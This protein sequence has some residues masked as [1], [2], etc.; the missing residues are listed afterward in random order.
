MKKFITEE[1]REA[2]EAIISTIKK[3]AEKWPT[4]FV[5]RQ[6]VPIFTGGAVSARTMANKDNL[7]EGPSCSFKIFKSV[8]YPVDALCDWLIAES[9]GTKRRVAQ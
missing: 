8:V 3:A 1:Q 9:S 6:Q 2:R 5:T 7:G 4:S